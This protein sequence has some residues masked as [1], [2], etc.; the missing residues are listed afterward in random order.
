MTTISIVSY[1]VP[2]FKAF[3]EK[4][5]RKAVKLGCPEITFSVVREFV[6]EIEIHE[7]YKA[8]KQTVITRAKLM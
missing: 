6:K 7:E 4:K 3:V 2:S 8:Q 5:N 1:N